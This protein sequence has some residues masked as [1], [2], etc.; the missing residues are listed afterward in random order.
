MP[1]KLDVKE[2]SQCITFAKVFYSFHGYFLVVTPGAQWFIIRNT[3]LF[4]GN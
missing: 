4:S 1:R 3:H 2:S